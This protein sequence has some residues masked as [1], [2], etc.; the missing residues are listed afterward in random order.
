MVAET[1]LKLRLS[2]ADARRVARLG[3]LR[4]VK[5]STRQLENVYYDTLQHALA[6]QKIALRHRR[7]GD[8]WLITVKT[9]EMSK[10]GLSTRPEWE[11]PCAPGELD[12]SGVDLKS[13]RQ[14][15]EKLRPQLAPLFATHFRRRIWMIEPHK[16]LSI[17]LALDEGEILATP[18]DKKGAQPLSRPI[19]E[20]ELELKHGS[21]LGL[22]ELALK[23]ADKL[24]LMP[25][26]ESKA[27][28]G[29]RLYRGIADAP[30]SATASRLAPELPPLV[31]FQ[32]LAHD[33]LNHF[34]ANAEGVR[35]A[36]DAEYV[37]QAR[38][39]LRRLRALMKVFSPRLPPDFLVT[40][41]EGWRY[42]SN[43]LGD[44]RDLDVL[45]EATLPTISRHYEGHDAIEAFTEYAQGKRLQVRESARASFYLPAMGRLTLRFLFDLARLDN[46]GSGDTLKPFAQRRLEKRLA[47]IRR[48]ASALDR[49][50]V[51]ELHDLRIQ[52]KRLRYALDFFTPLYPG[53]A[54]ADY[55]AALKSM[56]DI[57][58]QINDLER[59]L[60]IES[61]AP[62]AVRCELVAGWL[63]ASQ[64]SLI[65]ALPDAATRF[66]RLK[67]PWE[68]RKPR[69]GN[70][71]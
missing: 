60:A 34:L 42:F 51:D 52:F 23:L 48:D 56:Q 50:S 63:S 17:E 47:R 37:H 14:K 26:N 33:C 1:E 3:V 7:I 53:H 15:L 25:E 54:T 69:Q 13:L 22:F 12:F 30:K 40:Y 55:G 32:H 44:A 28:R 6:E 10:G 59:A 41:N 57:L 70:Q 35:R 58:G 19:C 20:L 29:Q 61:M 24:T 27:Q 31:A 71:K 65:A 21:P 38:V 45:V 68:P 62:D 43:Q 18:P 49:K 16:D 9:A 5:S 36:D 11:Y 46:T 66:N 39:A 8:T 2:P 67:A 4:G 64:Q